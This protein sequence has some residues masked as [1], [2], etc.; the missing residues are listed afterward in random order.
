M[1]DSELMKI[2]NTL[3]GYCREGKEA[4]GLNELYAENAV[5]AEAADMGNG[6]ETKGLEAIRGKHE[7]WNNAFEVHSAEGEGPFL[8]GQNS[9]GAVFSIDATNKETGER[10]K[11]TEMAF[12]TVES[13]KISREEFFYSAQD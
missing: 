4:Q 1:F 12:Y 11:M 2:A 8:H 3:V 10:N 7:W 5:S 13:G 9:F 6:A